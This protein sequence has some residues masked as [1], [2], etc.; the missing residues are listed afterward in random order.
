M[1]KF[2]S[3]ILSFFVVHVTVNT[4]AS[5]AELPQ[6]NIYLVSGTVWS[7]YTVVATVDIIAAFIIIIM[8]L[9]HPIIIRRGGNV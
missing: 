9:I 8:L 3:S 7:F 2:I 4:A 1:K 5:F 6:E